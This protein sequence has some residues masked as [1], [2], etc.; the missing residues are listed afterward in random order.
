MAAIGGATVCRRRAS[1]G[2]GGELVLMTSLVEFMSNII[3][4]IIIARP[5]QTKYCVTPCVI[6]MFLLQFGDLIIIYEMQPGPC[7]HQ[8]SWVM[9]M[10][11]ALRGRGHEFYVY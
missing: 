3:A 1:S 7:L 10:Y 11:G 4:H 9:S 5:T 2:G 6:V 8:N